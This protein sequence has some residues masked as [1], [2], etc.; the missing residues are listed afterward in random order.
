MVRAGWVVGFLLFLGQASAQTVP[1]AI[2]RAAQSPEFT[3]A[4][5][6]GQPCQ[7]PCTLQLVPGTQRLS[8]GGEQARAQSFSL[9]VPAAPVS[10]KVRARPR[11]SLTAGKILL[12]MAGL[13]LASG[14]ASI[15]IGYGTTGH[16]GSESDIFWQTP[17]FIVAGLQFADAFALTLMGSIYLGSSPRVAVAP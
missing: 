1:V 16:G 6:G 14:I 10:L 13:A 12:G 9:A 4:G 8:V 15:A 11:Q 7:V 2:E 17:A 5:P 3:I